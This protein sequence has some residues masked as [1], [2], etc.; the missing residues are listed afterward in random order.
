M[1]ESL[2]LLLAAGG[3]DLLVAGSAQN[4]SQGGLSYADFGDLRPEFA[5]S[6]WRGIL[7]RL[8]SQRYVVKRLEEG[9][10]G[11]LVQFRL[12]RLGEQWATQNLF[13]GYIAG[14]NSQ[15]SVVILK[16]RDGQKQRYSRARRYLEE[17]GFYHVISGVYA[18]QSGGYSDLLWQSLHDTGFMAVFMR[19]GATATQPIG[20]REL[21]GDQN[22]E[23]TFQRKWIRIEQ[24]LRK[25]IVR[26]E[27]EKELTTKEKAEIGQNVVSGLSL[28]GQWSPLLYADVI[29]R[30][31]V[32]EVLSLIMQVMA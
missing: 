23:Y 28:V 14:D 26:K 25:L 4:S 19:V 8:V 15:V 6:S 20:F 21:L 29:S 9:A 11:S 32:E 30:P 31:Q 1:R 13:S 17:Q 10:D 22:E 7:N 18:S 16:P 3:S 24:D 2:F 5:A 12:T 27:Q